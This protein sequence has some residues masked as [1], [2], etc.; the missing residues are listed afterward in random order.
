MYGG[1]DSNTDAF[2]CGAN[3]YIGQLGSG[4]KIGEAPCGGG[5]AFNTSATSTINAEVGGNTYGYWS[6]LGP[7]GDPSYNGTEAEAYSW[8]EK[9][10]T[11]AWNAYNDNANVVNITLFGDLEDYVP[12]SG[13]PSGIADWGW[14]SGN[15]ILNQQ[16]WEGFY[17]ELKSLGMNPGVYSYPNFWATYMGSGWIWRRIRDAMA[18]S[19]K[20]GLR[21]GPIDA[22]LIRGLTPVFNIVGD[23]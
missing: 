2:P 7:K 19:R 20:R 18:I 5:V 17:N 9:Q 22:Y 16:V 10:G 21:C 3:F 8:G 14:M 6:V 13:C 4:T 11:A 12:P 23:Y 1:C 15:Q